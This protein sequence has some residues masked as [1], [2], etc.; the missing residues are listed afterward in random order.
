MPGVAGRTQHLG[1]GAI[2]ILAEV[3]AMLGVPKHIRSD[4]GPVLLIV[5]AMRD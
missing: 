4:N 5:M 1:P 3:V 2:D